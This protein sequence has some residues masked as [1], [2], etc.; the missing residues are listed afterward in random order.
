MNGMGAVMAG[1]TGDLNMSI[2]NAASGKVIFMAIDT[3]LIDTVQFLC[4]QG[5]IT[6]RAA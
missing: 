3:G 2:V 1:K 4:S 6:H 5:F